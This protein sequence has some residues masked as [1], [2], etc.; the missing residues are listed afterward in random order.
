MSDFRMKNPL[1]VLAILPVRVYQL[2]ISPW[3]P[4]SC[5]YQPTCSDYALDALRQHGA[6]RGLWLTLRRIGRCHPWGGYGYDPV[7]ARS[8][9][10]CAD[11]ADAPQTNHRHPD[12]T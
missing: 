10:A 4:V 12:E 9:I 5:R 8:C 11:T 3:L 7:P 6:L 2:A 1:A